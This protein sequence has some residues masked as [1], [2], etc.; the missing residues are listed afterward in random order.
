MWKD[1]YNT[2]VSG[3]AVA[4]F[5]ASV[6][7][8][9]GLTAILVHRLPL[10]AGFVV[11]VYLLFS[12][13]VA[14]Q[15]QKVAVLRLGRY[16]GLRGPRTI[17]ATSSTS[18]PPRPG[19]G[20]NVRSCWPRRARAKTA[21]RFSKPSCAPPPMLRGARWLSSALIARPS[22]PHGWPLWPPPPPKCDGCLELIAVQAAA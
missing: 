5:V 12:I 6:A 3:V 2:Q 11:G 8:G 9:L 7:T 13:K 17:A 22:I 18:R 10:F 20:V 1:N 19:R 4:L 16:I 21:C 14:D 15:W